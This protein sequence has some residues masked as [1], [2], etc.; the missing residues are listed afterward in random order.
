MSPKPR[1]APALAP[2]AAPAAAAPETPAAAAPAA[3]PAP[4]PIPS[5]EDAL[6][7]A[8]AADPARWSLV[9]RVTEQTP[10][11]APKRVVIRCSDPQTKQDPDGVRRSVCEGE[12]EIATQD[13]F[14]VRCCAP[15]ADRLVR[16][17][18]RDRAK[19][20]DKSLRAAA[21]AARA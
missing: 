10:K 11:G 17:A 12:R 2:A 4:K 7:A 14:Q 16:R 19:R 21:R 6:A 9:L 15:C 1:T 5:P 8:R 3:A 18:R 20:R 13:L